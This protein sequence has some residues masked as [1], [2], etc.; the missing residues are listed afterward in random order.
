ML[1]GVGFRPTPDQC[2]AGAQT[3]HVLGVGD[4]VLGDGDTVLGVGDTVVGGGDTV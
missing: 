3:G 4:T 1:H 2:K